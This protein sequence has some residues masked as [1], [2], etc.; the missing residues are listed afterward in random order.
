M[1]RVE[2]TT[3]FKAPYHT[4][5]KWLNRSGPVLGLFLV[6]LVFGFLVGPQFFRAGNLELIAR[7]T[8]IVAVA[9]LGMTVVIASA[10]IDL[11]VGSVVS[12]STVVIALLLPSG[13]PPFA[14]V[15]AA[16]AAG[17][18]CGA[19][20]GLLVT[21]LRLLPF[22]VTL[23]MMLV[24]RGAAKGLA[25]EQRVEAP[26]TWINNLLRSPGTQSWLLL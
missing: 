4:S 14:A 25:D 8:A 5:A 17:V 2:A 26:I 1:A 23:G 24:V 12:L 13:V 21:R 9:S 20:V 18:L 16:I 15:L 7:Q 11:S 3:E 19:I 22:I 6:C 10:G